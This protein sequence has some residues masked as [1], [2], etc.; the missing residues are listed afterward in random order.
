MSLCDGED[1][2]DVVEEL[3]RLDVR[4]VVPRPPKA[5]QS[6]FVHRMSGTLVRG[7]YRHSASPANETRVCSLLV[8]EDLRQVIR[9]RL[10]ELF[11]RA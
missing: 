4:H 11:E 7:A 1:V 9:H 10:L 8:A 2:D 5:T 3:N 6:G